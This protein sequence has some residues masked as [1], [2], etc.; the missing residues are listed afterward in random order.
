MVLCEEERPMTDER[1][2]RQLKQTAELSEGI[3]PSTPAEEGGRLMRVAFGG[4]A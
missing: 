1:M 3:E 4:G 2:A